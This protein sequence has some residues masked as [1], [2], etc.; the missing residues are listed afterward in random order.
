MVDLDLKNGV[1]SMDKE[2]MLELINNFPRQCRD[3]YKIGEDFKISK[4]FA[5]GIENIVFA[6]MGGSAIGADLIRTYVKDEIKFPIDVIRSYTIPNY[7]GKN[8]LALVCSYSGNT[9]ETLSAYNFLKKKKARLIVLASGGEI[10]RLAKKDKAPH[11][12]IPQ[13]MPPRSALGF[14]AIPFLVVLSKLGLIKSKKQNILS[15]ADYL[16][17]LKKELC[18]SPNGGKNY[19]KSLAEKLHGK[20]IVLYGASEHTDAVVTRW[21]GQIAENSKALASSHIF[22]E[23]NHNEVVGWEYPKAVLENIAVVILR[24]KGDHPRVQKRMEITK[25]ILKKATDNIIEVESRGEDLLTRILSLIYIGDYTSVYL[26][27]LNKVDP[28][29]VERVMYLK[30]ELSKL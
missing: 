11:I 4:S 28:T 24:D 29:P 6:G 9:E 26:A 27:F 7:I 23:M 10:V 13:G 30:N 5:K 20:F 15:A 14:S 3:A 21:R 19:A 16:E 8:T 12:I 18:A 22:P 25:Y 1:S 17:R 2:G